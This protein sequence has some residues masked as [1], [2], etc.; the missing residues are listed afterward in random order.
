MTKLSTELKNKG[1]PPTPSKKFKCNDCKY[2]FESEKKKR[3][4]PKCKSTNIINT[5]TNTKTKKTNKTNNK[6]KTCR[7][8]QV[9]VKVKPY[10]S[11]KF[12]NETK[13]FTKKVGFSVCERREEYEDV[14]VVCT[15]CNLTFYVHPIHVHESFKCDSCI[16]QPTLD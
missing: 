3:K 6:N 9:K 11:G 12:K 2:S 7:R 4:C 15:G 13:E 8:E 10:D 16:P 1:Q 14:E 5:Q